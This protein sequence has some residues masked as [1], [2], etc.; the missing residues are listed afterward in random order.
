MSVDMRQ[1]PASATLGDQTYYFC[2]LECK[3]AF[4]ELGAAHELQGNSRELVDRHGKPLAAPRTKNGMV[5]IVFSD[6]EASTVLMEEMGQQAAHAAVRAE[7]ERQEETVERHG[8]AVVKRLGDGLM[9]AFPAARSALL[10]AIDIQSD[11]PQSAMVPVRIGMHTGQVITD[12]DDYFG[13]TVAM[14]A[15]LTERARGGEIVLT[16]GLRSLLDPP[17]GWSFSSPRRVRL[18]GFPGW[19]RMVRVECC[20]AEAE[21]RQTN[22][23]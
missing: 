1:P 13:K 12:G 9:A 17:E 7:L 3:Q 22:D 23:H 15:R 8:G 16:D 5:T 19:Q 14:A 21:S 2:A 18:K 11:P 10:C 4:L 6:V 20:R